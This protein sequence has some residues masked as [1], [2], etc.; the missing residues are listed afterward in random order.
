MK[1]LILILAILASGSAFAQNKVEAVQATIE[2]TPAKVYIPSTGDYVYLGKTTAGGYALFISR[3]SSLFTR[4]VSKGGDSIVNLQGAVF[5]PL[6]H[7]TKKQW[8]MLSKEVK[9]FFP[10][11]SHEELEK[12]NFYM[13]FNYAIE[14]KSGIRSKTPGTTNTTNTTNTGT[15]VGPV[16][17]R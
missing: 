5:K 9:I 6:N 3:D 8:K 10:A 2:M 13:V 1:K 17:G 14:P 15:G 7:Y 4:F 12:I 16:I 11:I